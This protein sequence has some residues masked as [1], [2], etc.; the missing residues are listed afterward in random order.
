VAFL[1]SFTYAEELARETESRYPIR[2]ALQP[3]NASAADLETFV[4]TSL[5]THDALVLVL[6]SSLAEAVD[7][8]GGRVSHA[9]V[10]GPALPEVN[11]VQ[12]AKLR[13]WSTLG[14]EAAFRRTYL[15]PGMS[16]VNQA[17]GR[18]VRA[19]GQHTQVLL[20]CRRFADVRYASLL[21][22]AYQFFE[23]IETDADMERWLR[24]GGD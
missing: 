20:H 4:D 24:G 21:D 3:R 12:E 11:P 15:I 2:V 5:V 6:G 16:R 17:I 1:P 7:I 14:R 19:P 23:T 8:L 18:L 10:V 9:I 22:R 13:H